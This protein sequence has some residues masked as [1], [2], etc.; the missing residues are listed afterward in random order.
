[1]LNLLLLISFIDAKKKKKIQQKL[2]IT[3]LHGECDKKYR[4]QPHKMFFGIGT[5]ARGP[6]KKGTKRNSLV[7][8]S[9][10]EIDRTN[11]HRNIHRELRTR[12][13]AKAPLCSALSFRARI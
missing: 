12:E 1:M 3:A 5:G 7:S 10:A 6:E 2:Y 11:I 9:Q 8:F 13:I 4:E